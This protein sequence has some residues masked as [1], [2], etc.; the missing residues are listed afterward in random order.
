MQES[1]VRAFWQAHPC[2]DEQVGGLSQ[3][4]D[5]DV[6]RFFRAYDDFR[7]KK[8]G[9]ILAALDRF[10]WKGKRV[11]EIGIGQGADAEQLIKRGAIWSGLDLT[12]ESVDRMK[13]RARVH[14]LPIE[15]IEVGSALQ[16]PFETGAFDVVF[17]H[18]VLHHIPDIKKAQSEIR[19][20]LKP[21]GSL[22]VM[23][24]AKHSLNYHVSIRI[25][26]RLVLLAS[27]TL[28]IKLPE[29]HDQH[30]LNCKKMGV[31]NYLRMRNFI[32]RSTDGPRNPYAKVYTLDGIKEDFSDFRV[33]ESFKMWLH[34]PPLPSHL[35][36]GG[37]LL[38][39]HLWARLEPK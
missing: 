23:L 34:A 35:F 29:P 6:E 5:G 39:W 25:V 10:D 33:V 18:G 11:L 21:N 38:G 22:I 2:G 32:H 16:I 8:E 13:A 1:D 12:P 28:G 3:F 30:R 9:H 36:P 26:R 15:R 4:Y 14:Q 27:Y 17:S 37:S 24:Y 20:V 19:R 31:I 7:Y